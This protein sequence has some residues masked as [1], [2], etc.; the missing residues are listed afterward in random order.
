MMRNML[1]ALLVAVTS[2]P[3][4]A[5]QKNSAKPDAEPAL[6][7]LKDSDT[8]IYLFGTFHTLDDRTSWFGEKLRAAFDSSG[9]LMLETVVP[10]AAPPLSTV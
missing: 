5:Q 2:A 4:L 1:L 3:A 7:V 9:E 8:T 6:W 10:T